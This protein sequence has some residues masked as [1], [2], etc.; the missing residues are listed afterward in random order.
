MASRLNVDFNSRLK[1]DPFFLKSY[2][3]SERGKF[4]ASFEN[5]NSILMFFPK[6]SILGRAEGGALIEE[7]NKIELPVVEK[8]V[9]SVP[10]RLHECI[11]MKDYPTKYEL[12][13]I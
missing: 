2:I 6:Q 11:K 7:W 4:A 5:K 13:F 10:S 8:L 9:D 12:S 1:F 3:Y